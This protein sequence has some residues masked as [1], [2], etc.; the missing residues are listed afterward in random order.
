M[1]RRLTLFNIV[2]LVSGLAFLYLP[3]VVLIAYSFNASAL[4]G[5]GGFSTDWYVA[6]LHDRALRY[7]GLISLRVAF[8]SATIAAILGAFAAIVL[9][10][11]RRFAGKGL[12]RSLVHAQIVMPE[13][14]T[15]LALLLLFVAVDIDRG[16]MTVM[17]AHATFSMCFVAIIVQIR[18][19]RLDRA[20][21]DAAIDLGAPPARAFMFAILPAL[22]P[23]I[24]AGWMLAFALSLGDL[25]IAS[26]TTGPGTTTLPMVIY[27]QIRTGVTPQINAL[28]TVM[29]AVVTA[30][31]LIGSV[32]GKVRTGP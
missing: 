2:F 6:I 13:I 26:F 17:I 4:D 21:L 15:G 19:R 18:L 22:L 30:G 27:A 31:V 5:W 20:L 10:R 29:V 3:L 14:I 12:F 11:R 9:D 25:V 23:A 16:F 24:G 7:A 28:C 32:I 1:N 8:W